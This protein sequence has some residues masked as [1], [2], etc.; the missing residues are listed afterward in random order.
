MRVEGFFEWLGE[1]LGTVIRFIVD[2]LSG[3][4]GFLAGAGSNFLEGLARTLGID[5]SLV[6]LGALLVGLML[7]AAAVRALLRGSIIAALIWLF[8]GL[9]LLSWLIH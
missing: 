2:A 5:P 8:L 3:V 7:L 6:S 4:F 9:W 1:A